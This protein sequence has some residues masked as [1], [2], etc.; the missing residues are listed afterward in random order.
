MLEKKKKL[1]IKKNLFKTK[2][3]RVLN[4]SK[5]LVWVIFL[6]LYTVTCI[7]KF[8]V[9]FLIISSIKGW[10]MG[11]ITQSISFNDTTTSESNYHLMSVCLYIY[12]ELINDKNK[13]IVCLIKGLVI[14]HVLSD[15]KAD[16][17]GSRLSQLLFIPLG[18]LNETINPPLII[19][20]N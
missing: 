10:T 16:S 5:T 4:S 6:S 11:M 15:A 2:S 3:N 18:S 17:I 20:I 14:Y 1:W 8:I 12:S 13:K 19:S 9:Y 7:L